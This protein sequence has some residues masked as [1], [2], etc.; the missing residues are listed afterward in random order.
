M[1]KA[2]QSSGTNDLKMSTSGHF[3]WT[4]R[5]NIID[6]CQ[7]SRCP[8]FY[9]EPICTKKGNGWMLVMGRMRK[10][11]GELSIWNGRTF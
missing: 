11:E 2:S 8:V 4:A 7:S 9:I 10:G 1:P 5:S 6:F 3:D